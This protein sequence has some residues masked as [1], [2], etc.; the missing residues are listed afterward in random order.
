M[1]NYHLGNTQNDVMFH[2]RAPVQPQLQQATR[3]VF[4][5]QVENVDSKSKDPKHDYKCNK[6]HS[7]IARTLGAFGTWSYFSETR[8]TI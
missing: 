6:A 4:E 7:A 8:F 3:L 5:G 2:V 1:T